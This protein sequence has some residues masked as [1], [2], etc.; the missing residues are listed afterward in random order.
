M[1]TMLTVL[2]W[3]ADVVRVGGTYSRHISSLNDSSGHSGIFE[4]WN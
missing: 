3:Y 1:F 4:V 2:I